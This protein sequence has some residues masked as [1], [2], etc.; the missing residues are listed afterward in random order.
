MIIKFPNGEFDVPAMKVREGLQFKKDIKNSESSDFNEIVLKAVEVCLLRKYDQQTV[1]AIFDA[2]D[3]PDL[4]N[5]DFM[6]ALYNALTGENMSRELLAK[7]I[8]A[9]PK[10]SAEEKQMVLDELRADKIAVL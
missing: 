4:N 1:D 10:M 9:N 8:S 7:A 3:Y 6:F 2:M 5:W